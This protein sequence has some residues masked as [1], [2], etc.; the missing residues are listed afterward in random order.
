MANLQFKL[1]C[2]MHE[3]ERQKWTFKK[4]TRIFVYKEWLILVN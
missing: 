4:I 2:S 1:A 3:E